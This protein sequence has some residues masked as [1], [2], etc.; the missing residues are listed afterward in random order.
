MALNQTTFWG[1]LLFLIACNNHQEKKIEELKQ[2]GQVL[3]KYK[4]D[5]LLISDIS[6]FL[7]SNMNKQDSQNIIDYQRSLWLRDKALL[8]EAENSLSPEE[9]NK[10]QEIKEYYRDLLIYEYNSKIINKLLDTIITPAEIKAYYEQNPN[11]FELKENIV[12]LKYFI[13]PI[14]YKKAS[15][16]WG[17]ILNNNPKAILR[18]IS[19]AKIYSGKLFLNDSIWLPFNS[20]LSDIPIETYNQEHFLSN[21]KYLKISDN[22]KQYFVYIKDFKIKNSLSPLEFEIDKIRH[23]ILNK[24]KIE[25]LKENEKALLQKAILNDDAEIY[26]P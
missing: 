3:A 16:L 23:I 13:L 7:D 12:R 4:Q 5:Y 6:S 22:A 24:R 8:N 20:I 1:I 10:S 15:Q 18:A 21:N 19:L 14:K 11:N 9:K 2:K 25:L 17:E 26:E